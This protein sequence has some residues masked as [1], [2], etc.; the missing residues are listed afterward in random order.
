MMCRWAGSWITV[1]N[2]TTSVLKRNRK[3]FKECLGWWGVYIFV[4][5]QPFFFSQQNTTPWCSSK[6]STPKG[7]RPY[8]G[9]VVC[10]FQWPIELCRQESL[11]PG[12]ATHNWYF[13]FS[14]W[15]CSKDRFGINERPDWFKVQTN[16]NI[17]TKISINDRSRALLDCFTLG[18]LQLLSAI[19][20]RLSRLETKRRSPKKKNTSE[21]VMKF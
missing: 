20:H 13:Q 6:R 16:L 2:F 21:M 3:A 1:Y 8:R 18:E 14:S 4:W 11:T 12:R 9:G 19:Y 10:V 15:D 7:R 5:Y 17:H